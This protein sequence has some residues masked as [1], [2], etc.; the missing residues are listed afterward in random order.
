MIVLVF[1]STVKK[2]ERYNVHVSIHC[3]YSSYVCVA[4]YTPQ[5][6]LIM[7]ML[8][9]GGGMDFSIETGYR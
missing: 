1:S 5:G 7:K 2:W 8:G 9:F 4:V 3:Y 6:D